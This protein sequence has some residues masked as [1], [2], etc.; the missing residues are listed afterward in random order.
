MRQRQRSTTVGAAL[1]ALFLTCWVWAAPAGVTTFA[2]PEEA[3]RALQNALRQRDQ[4]ALL[5]LFGPDFAKV[6]AQDPGERPNTYD[7]L[8]RLF[9]ESWSL[10]TTQDQH[11]VLRLGYEGW[12]FPIPLVKKGSRW[13]F[14]TALGLEELANRRV[15]RNELMAIDTI[16][17]LQHAQQLYKEQFGKYADRLVSSAGQKD[18]LYWPGS[19][20][21]GW[22]PLQRTIGA[23]ATMAGNHR[24]GAP[25]HGYYYTLTIAGEGSGYTIS[26]WPQQYRNTG[27]MSFWGDQAGELYEKDLGA[28][29]GALLRSMVSGQRPQD[30]GEPLP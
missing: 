21:E 25:W 9:K 26:A 19:E 4:A 5:A 22:S 15:G 10:T 11:R 3:A 28:N 1:V 6:Q 30:W 16:R 29:G 14:D 23:V 18:G 20:A 8:S 12:S 2:S 7:R 27:V 13:S 24:K 17:Q